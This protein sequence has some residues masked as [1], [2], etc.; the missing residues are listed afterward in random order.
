MASYKRVN[1]TEIEP[2]SGGMH[3]LGD[4]LDSEQMGVTIVR[5]EPHWRSRKHDHTDDGHEEVYVLIEGDATVVIDDEPVE[6]E[7][8]DAVWIPPEAT[9]QIRNGDTES[10][11]VMVSTPISLDPTDDSEWTTDGFVG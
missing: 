9:R 1:Y 6:M 7:R 11:F 2:V 3:F 10:A 4:A 5:C 8:G